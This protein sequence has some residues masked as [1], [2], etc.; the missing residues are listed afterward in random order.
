MNRRPVS[1]IYNHARF[2]GAAVLGI[3]AWLATPWLDDAPFRL[4]LAGDVFFASHIVAMAGLLSHSRRATFRQRAK[5]GDDG[6][7]LIAA[8]T[9]AA[10][11]LCLWSIFTLVNPSG[12]PNP[13]QFVVAVASV[14]LAW[15][16]LHTVSAFHYA[17]VYYGD[18]ENEDKPGG[19]LRF[20]GG[21][22]P[23]A[24]DFMY[25]AF[26]V[27]MTAQVSDV[28]ILTTRMRRLTLAH[29]V[30]SFFFNTVILAIVV[31]VTVNLAP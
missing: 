7:A 22:E 2:Y 23:G 14:P 25:Y 20:P 9:F 8:I 31:N 27:G 15:F 19:G 1:N 13:Y 5:S 10:V 24:W 6:L 17:H 11:V 16:M 4:L 29:A 28:S 18:P 3:G 26:V 30:V 21:K 12:R